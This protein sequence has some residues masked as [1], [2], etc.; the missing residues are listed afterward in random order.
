MGS[1]KPF[2]AR[3]IRCQSSAPGIPLFSL[4]VQVTHDS[5]E[6]QGVGERVH[7]RLTVELGDDRLDLGEEAQQRSRQGDDR[8]VLL[9]PKFV[10]L[11]PLA[12][13][14][15][16]ARDARPVVRRELGPF[17]PIDLPA[18]ADLDAD[19][20]GVGLLGVERALDEVERLIDGAV[21]VDHEVRR[22]PASVSARTRTVVHRL[23][24]GARVDAAVE[25]QHELRDSRLQAHPGF[26]ARHP[27]ARR[28]AWTRRRSSRRS[29]RC[30]VSGR[31]RIPPGRARGPRDARPAKAWPATTIELP[32]EAA[33]SSAVAVLLA[34]T[35]AAMRAAATF[36]ACAII[37]NEKMAG[38]FDRQKR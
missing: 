25:V 11:V 14:G 15:H 33:D 2:K 38:A 4:D 17:A 7:D 3:R 20:I 35:I 34:M 27:S 28:S 16:L 6:G 19:R 30:T 24:T 18:V 32:A 21:G 5:R 10:G 13:D 37:G 26:P 12:V 22:E 8:L 1:S 29:D 23:E 31:R 36:R 9:G